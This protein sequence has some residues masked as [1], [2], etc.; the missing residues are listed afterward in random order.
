MNFHQFLQGTSLCKCSSLA[1]PLSSTRP[2][3]RTRSNL[4]SLFAFLADQVTVAALEDPAGGRH[5]L[6]RREAAVVLKKG[7]TTF[8]K[9]STH[10]V[11][12][13]ALKIFLKDG[14]AWNRRRGGSS[15]P[16]EAVK[17]VQLSF[18]DL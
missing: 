10:L 11:A 13:W 3:S 4:L 5:H 18:G 7:K 12:D 8:V 1:L 9:S 16:I 6:G 14:I 15:H 17:C 2:A